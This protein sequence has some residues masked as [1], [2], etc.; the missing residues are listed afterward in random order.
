MTHPET[1]P[2]ALTAQELEVLQQLSRQKDL[3]PPAVLRQALHTYQAIEWVLGQDQ[4][5][6]LVCSPAGIQVQPRLAYQDS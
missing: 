4:G 6:V 5:C 3:S 1:V 2:V